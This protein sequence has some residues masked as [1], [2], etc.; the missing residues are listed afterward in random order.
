MIRRSSSRLPAV[1]VAFIWLAPV[2]G[3]DNSIEAKE[4]LEEPLGTTP[5]ADD[6]EHHRQLA[7]TCAS[8]TC[9]YNSGVRVTPYN[10]GALCGQTYSNMP[11]VPQCTDSLTDGQE[12]WVPID[13]ITTAN[14]CG[15]TSEYCHKCNDMAYSSC[16]ECAA[17]SPSL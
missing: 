3:A 6:Q 12:C 17:P 8:S 11:N 16:S 2:T 10:S 4:R 9:V 1:L 14:G 5:V 15:P 7:E 13:K